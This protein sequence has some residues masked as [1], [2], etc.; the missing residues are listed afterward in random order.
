MLGCCTGKEVEK[1]TEVIGDDDTSKPMNQKI[2]TYAN[3]VHKYTEKGL[4][5]VDKLIESIKTK[6]DIGNKKQLVKSLEHVSKAAGKVCI[7]IGVGVSVAEALGV[8]ESPEDKH[9]AAVMEGLKEIKGK[10][11]AG[12]QDLKDFM[13]QQHAEVEMMLKLDA[14]L[15]E[16]EIQVEQ[17]ERAT[18]GHRMPILK[19]KMCSKLGDLNENIQ[20]VQKAIED[21]MVFDKYF[22]IAN[23]AT[24]MADHYIDDKGSGSTKVH[25][26]TLMMYKDDERMFRRYRFLIGAIKRYNHCMG[27]VAAGILLVQRIAMANNV[28]E[29]YEDDSL[30]CM[31]LLSSQVIDDPASTLKLRTHLTG[32]EKFDKTGEEVTVQQ[33]LE[34]KI[35]LVDCNNF[36]FNHYKKGKLQELP[37]V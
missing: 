14:P 7:A 25:E 27:V 18:P 8:V 26:A 28:W 3:N 6:E 21:D 36:E 34:M 4:S 9:H 11:D 35:F 20:K 13:K 16:I 15:K 10:I 29:Q 33:I 19:G 2:L 32:N 31:E 12:F 17:Y 5:G 24:Q 37:D 23:V 22:K 30:H 1:G